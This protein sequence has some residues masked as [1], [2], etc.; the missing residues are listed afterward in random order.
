MTYR[1][2][3]CAL[4]LFTS[5]LAAQDTTTRGVRIGLT[6]D[7]GSKLGVVVLRGAGTG[8]DSIRAI[9][10]RDLD[11]GDRISVIRI[12]SP[13]DTGRDVVPNWA[14]LA[15]L[16]AAAAVQITPTPTGMHLAVYD[17]AKQTTALVREYVAPA[18][19]DLRGWRAA[20]HGLSDDIEESF[21]GTRGIARTRVLFERAKRIYVA[22]SDGE[23]V[24]ALTP[25][26]SVMSPSWSP[27]GQSMVYTNWQPPAHVVVHDLTTG[28]ERTVFSGGG[29]S[30]T[31][32]F[33]PDGS[34]IAFGHGVD[35]G[36]DIY[37][38]DAAGTNV[39]RLSVGHGSDNTS[40]T[41]SPDGRRLAFMS[42]RAGHPELYTMD[43]DGANFSPLTP[44]DFGENAYR[45]NPDWSPAGQTVAFQSMI[46]GIFQIMTI[47]LRDLGMK[48][49]TSDGKNEEPS[50][51]P[52]GRH[53]VFSSNRSG[54][55]Q[56]WVVDVETGRTR[57]LTR[58][59]AV[60]NPSWSPRLS[61]N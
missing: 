6:Y 39:R 37:A 47:N 41:F 35:D 32:V 33:S 44:L 23:Q 54:S 3:F 50:W 34:T 46:S 18:M 55:K 15:K 60:R 53:L 24:V 9:V 49:L 22:D 26:A 12:D 8:A 59:A 27:N 30:V 58:G 38:V 31:P 14:V 40:P 2:A 20:L 45:A 36:V 48:Q 57:Q 21:T 51:A 42:G 17:V 7:P 56:L 61:S 25:T 29:V 4:L 28:R 43:A 5:P 13:S 16:G 52:D 1:R 19:S 10:Q 11:F